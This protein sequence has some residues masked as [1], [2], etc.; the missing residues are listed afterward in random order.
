VTAGHFLLLAAG[1]GFVTWLTRWLP[2]AVLTGRRLPAWFLDW[3][4]LVPSAVLGALA[5]ALVL[6]GGPG[7]LPR[8]GPEF[9]VALPTLAVAI[10]T[11][12][13]GWT[14]TAGMGFYWVTRMAAG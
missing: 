8:V 6:P 9:W 10:L 14:V 4:D 3:L 13:M 11:R 1:M 7:T 2:L 5:A 12:S